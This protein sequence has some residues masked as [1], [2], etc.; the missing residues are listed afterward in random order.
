MFTL[1]TLFLSCAPLCCC[2]RAH[3]STPQLFVFGMKYGEF[4]AHLAA[5]A[6]AD[7]PTQEIPPYPRARTT[8]EPTMSIHL[9]NGVVSCVLLRAACL[10]RPQGGCFDANHAGRH[11][12]AGSSYNSPFDW[13]QGSPGN[14]EHRLVVVLWF[15]RDQR[16]PWYAVER[17]SNLPCLAPRLLLCGKTC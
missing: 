3:C 2:A 10:Q 14:E 7:H 17:K 9:S 4:A 13:Q 12:F 11:S 6:L 8:P 5:D 16:L 1:L 15:E